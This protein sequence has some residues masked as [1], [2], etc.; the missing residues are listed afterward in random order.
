[1]LCPSADEESRYA[2]GGS[3]REYMNLIV[4]AMEPFLRASG[5]S[6]R[7]AAPDQSPAQCI[8]Q[9]NE[10]AVDLFL[11]LGTE[12]S[13]P[14]MYGQMSGADFYFLPSI[15]AG[16]RAAEAMAIHLKKIHPFP[17]KVHAASS[18]RQEELKDSLVPAVAAKL[19]H[20]DN[21]LDVQWIKSSVDAVA[22]N[23]AQSVT[24]ILGTP[25]IMPQ[26]VRTGIVETQMLPLNIR[27]RPSIYAPILGHIPKGTKLT[28][29]GSSGD[30]YVVAYETG[31]GFVS[32]HYIQV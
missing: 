7:K 21:A 30:W 9:A 2:G 24:R 1:M 13:P 11:S 32:A 25:F 16:R 22:R 29:F 6:F 26:P 10:S 18:L 14:G 4:D 15:A 5:I 27:S 3:D 28:I 20:S 17:A 23:L 8:T 19:C 12:S 31:Y